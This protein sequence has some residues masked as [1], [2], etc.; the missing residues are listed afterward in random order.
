MCI[1]N[2]GAH[3]RANKKPRTKRG[4][5]ILAKGGD[6]PRLSIGTTSRRGSPI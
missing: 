3:F 2:V 4:F 1:A 5:H 6:H